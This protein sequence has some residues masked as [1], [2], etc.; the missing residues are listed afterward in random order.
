MTRYSPKN[1]TSFKT[2]TKNI[3]VMTGDMNIV[4]VTDKNVSTFFLKRSSAHEAY[5][6]SPT[7]V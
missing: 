6:H 5:K 2:K 3:F 7:N 4:T 1:N